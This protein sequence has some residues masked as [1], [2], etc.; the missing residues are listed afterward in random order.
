MVIRSIIFDCFGVLVVPGYTPLFTMFP[1]KK[2]QIND[3]ID[4]GNLGQITRP[5]YLKLV[6]E[7]V[8]ITPEDVEKIYETKYFRNEK[9]IDWIKELKKSG[10]FKI[11][12]LSNIGHGWIEEFFS[13]SELDEL[14]D[15][16]ILSGDVRMAKPGLP[17]YEMMIKKLKVKPGECLMFDD[18]PDNVEA[19]KKADM[20]SVVFD[21]IEQASA[22]LAWM[23]EL[24]DA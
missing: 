10:K 9:A 19:A 14:F 1:D 6:G 23:L 5:E 20:N 16:V 8:G 3:L 7:L 24:P 2:N 18:R 13:K 17:I 12:L 4:K 21:S 11:A 22:E 15:E